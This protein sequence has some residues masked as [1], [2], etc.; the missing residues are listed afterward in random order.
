MINKC[1]QKALMEK[2]N[3]YFIYFREKN[4]VYLNLKEKILLNI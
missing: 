2:Y 4:S 3:M 1:K